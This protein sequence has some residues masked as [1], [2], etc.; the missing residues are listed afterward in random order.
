M[1]EVTIKGN[2]GP[3]ERLRIMQQEDGDIILT[4]F[5][6]DEASRSGRSMASIEFAAPHS[7]HRRTYHALHHLM[8]AMEKDAEEHQG[9]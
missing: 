9:L 8:D 1:R 2:M 4:I 6:S 7:K 5:Q 3:D